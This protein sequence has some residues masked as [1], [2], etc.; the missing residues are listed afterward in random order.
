MTRAEIKDKVL[1][2]GILAI[3]RLINRKRKDKYIYCG[4]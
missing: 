3:K 1:E 4:F 2:G